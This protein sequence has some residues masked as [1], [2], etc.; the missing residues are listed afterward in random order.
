MPWFWTIVAGTLLTRALLFPFSVLQMRGTAALAPHTDEINKIRDAMQAAQAKRDTLAMQHAALRQK[1]IYE[2]AGV[3]MPGMI[4]SP[5]IQLPVTLG[6]F[7]G[8]KRLCDF[9]L[10]QLKHSGVS[11]LQD[12]TVA[13][14]TYTLPILVT[15]L[16]NVQISVRI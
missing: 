4:L 12:L 16:M 9:P 11:F 1:M 7:F 14:P 13:D 5:F 8:V 2:K 6:M 3:S 10:E 15:V